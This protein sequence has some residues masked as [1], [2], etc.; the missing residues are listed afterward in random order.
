M[1]PTAIDDQPAYVVDV[2]A[3][4]GRLHHFSTWSTTATT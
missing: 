3:A 4:H 2:K 1:S